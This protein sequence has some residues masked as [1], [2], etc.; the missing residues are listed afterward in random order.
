MDS[1]HAYDSASSDESDIDVVVTDVVGSQQKDM[2]SKRKPLVSCKEKMTCQLDCKRPRMLNSAKGEELKSVSL[3]DRSSGRTP[4]NGH[5]ETSTNPT[6]T[7]SKHP[8]HFLDRNSTCFRSSLHSSRDNKVSETCSTRILTLPRSNSLGRGTKPYIP[9]RERLTR[10]TDATKTNTQ[11]EMRE[12]DSD[13]K[14]QD[15][16]SNRSIDGSKQQNFKSACRPP[17]Q[18]HLS[19]QGHSQGVNCVRWNPS[20]SNLLLSASMDHIV[21]IWDTRGSGS[22]VRRFTCHTEAVKD[23]TW[24][25]CGT[26]VLSCGYDKTARLSDLQTGKICTKI[27]VDVGHNR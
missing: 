9:K 8:F 17:K 7:T 19:F 22:C 1:L 27:N 3:N 23:S 11:P 26:Q 14:F 4:K 12:A 16:D 15:I 2:K 21:C 20:R 13:L 18:L 25:L 10:I 5:H 24:S 6:I